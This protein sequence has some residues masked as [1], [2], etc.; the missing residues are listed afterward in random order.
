MVG[1]CLLDAKLVSVQMK[2]KLAPHLVAMHYCAHCTNL[3]IQT[4]S[5][6]FIMHHLEDLL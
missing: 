4:L 2:E 5:S 1:L 3:A 6:L